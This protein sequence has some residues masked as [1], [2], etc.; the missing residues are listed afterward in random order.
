MVR[1]TIAFMS[2][3]FVACSIDP[4]LSIPQSAGMKTELWKVNP[5]TLV[6]AQGNIT[7][8]ISKEPGSPELTNKPYLGL[9]GTGSLGGI[10]LFPYPG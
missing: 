3:F 8:A 10:S 2:L 9:Y 7:E 4:K 6:K 1:I 5:E